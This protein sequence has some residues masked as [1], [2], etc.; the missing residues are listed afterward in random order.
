MLSVLCLPALAAQ[1]SFV[2]AHGFIEHGGCEHF[3]KCICVFRV[4]FEQHAIGNRRS[5]MG[6]RSVQF[7][8]TVMFNRMQRVRGQ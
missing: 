6:A 1:E 4:T 3:T 8:G 7:R 5:A 2:F